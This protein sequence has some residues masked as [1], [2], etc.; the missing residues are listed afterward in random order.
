MADCGDY[1][2]LDWCL[3]YRNARALVQMMRSGVVTLAAPG[4]WSL[5]GMTMSQNPDRAFRFPGEVIEHAVWLYHC[6]SFSL[7]L[8]LSL[9]DVELILAARGIVVSYERSSSGACFRK[10]P[11]AGYR[12]WL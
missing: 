11:F 5:P 9:R 4:S 2:A 10:P 1:C 8:S 6:F 7:S 12:N 3:I